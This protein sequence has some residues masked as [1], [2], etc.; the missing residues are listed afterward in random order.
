MFNMDHC[1]YF[2][3]LMNGSNHLQE[4]DARPMHLCP[5]CLRKLHHS[6]GFD[7]V[8]RYRNLLGFW[9]ERQG[10]PEAT[11]CLRAAQASASVTIA[12]VFGGPRSVRAASDGHT[13]DSKTGGAPSTVPAS[14]N[15]A[16]EATV[17]SEPRLAYPVP[18]VYMHAE[19]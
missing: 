9:K 1:V 8:E 12:T 11:D 18:T 3:C 7:P 14:A 6:V 17:D 4:S 2:H 16:K 10:E 5:V 13:G 19:L 15:P